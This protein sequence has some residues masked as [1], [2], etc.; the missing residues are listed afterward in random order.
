MDLLGVKCVGEYVCE[1]VLGV[2]VYGF[3]VI[4]YDE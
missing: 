3:Y 2:V 4:V 1:L